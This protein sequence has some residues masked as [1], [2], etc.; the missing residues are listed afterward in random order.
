MLVGGVL[1]GSWACVDVLVPS[2]VARYPLGWQRLILP[3]ATAAINQ[4]ITPIVVRSVS[5]SRPPALPALL[6]LCMSL[7]VLLLL[8]AVPVRH[9]LGRD[10]V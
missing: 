1:V 2:R 10:V 5:A 3:L 8:L 9:V 4:F 6:C 7:H